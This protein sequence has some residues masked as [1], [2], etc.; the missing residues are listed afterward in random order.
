MVAEID[1]KMKNDINA[2]RRKLINS[3]NTNPTYPQRNSQDDRGRFQEQSQL[4]R[5]GG[6]LP[7]EGRIDGQAVQG[8]MDGQ[9]VFSRSPDSSENRIR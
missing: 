7:P 3:L 1:H 4:F 9:A 2:A 6:R 8:R 5:V